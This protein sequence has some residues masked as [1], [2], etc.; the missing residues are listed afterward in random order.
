MSDT[1]HTSGVRE[2]PEEVEVPWQR[3]I[4][5]SGGISRRPIPGYAGLQRAL[6][7][8][9]GVRFSASGK[10]DLDRFQWRPRAVRRADR[11]S[12]TSDPAARC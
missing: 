5:A 6:L 4:N 2:M 8:R 1:I 7:E 3:V 12:G 11:L 10:V 9:E